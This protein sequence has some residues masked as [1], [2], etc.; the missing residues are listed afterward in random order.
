MIRDE[1]IQ[2][3]PCLKAT[4]VRA[5]TCDCLLSLPV[6]VV[7]DLTVHLERMVSA[8]YVYTKECHTALQAATVF[9]FQMELRLDIVSQ[10]REFD[11]DVESLLP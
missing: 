1:T 8:L 5:S 11:D 2:G 3:A 10:K 4:S 9:P 7:H 6:L